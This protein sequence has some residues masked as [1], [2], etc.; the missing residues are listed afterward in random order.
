MDRARW[1]PRRSI[2]PPIFRPFRTPDRAFSPLIRRT[3]PAHLPGAAPHR[4]N[5]RNPGL[6]S[7][8]HG[9]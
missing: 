9:L 8:R 1:R 3:I 4:D 7:R 5:M 2:R 6:N